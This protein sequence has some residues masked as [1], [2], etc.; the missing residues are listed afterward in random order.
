MHSELERTTDASQVMTQAV[1]AACGGSELDRFFEIRELPVNCIALFRTREAALDCP[2]AEIE[3]AFC[4]GCGAVSNLEFDSA[5]LTYDRSY[6]NSLHFS[7]T[8]QKYA[9]EVAR[10]L[11]ECYNLRGKNIID[12]GCG[13]AEFLSLVCGLGDNRGVGFD[14]TFIAGRADLRA[15]QGITII[16]D[17]YSERYAEYAADFVICRHVLEHIANPRQF[18]G[19]VRTALVEKS[20]AAIFFELP[21]ASF[22][23]RKTGMWDIIYEHCFYYSPGALARLFS[24]C[25]F[26]VC[27][28]SSTFNGQYLCLEARVSSREIGRLG[29][30]GGDLV[31]MRDDIGKFSEEYRSCRTHWGDTLRRLEGQRKRVALWGAGAKGATFLNAL[32]DVNSI[33]YIVDVNPNKWGLY[34]PGTGQ[35][36]VGPEFLKQFRPDVLLIVNPNYSAEISGQVRALGIAPELLS[37]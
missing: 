6:D 33:E 4:R 8:F 7:P 1:C 2:K 27:D 37:I 22:V 10:D 24:A 15:G 23:F 31:S 30:A 28:V 5:R 11:V 3:L 34:I 18:L 12:V 36:V 29:D 35:R 25:G 20:D 19:S 21:N 13:N 26:D 14:P 17:Y 32:R 9:D 16:P